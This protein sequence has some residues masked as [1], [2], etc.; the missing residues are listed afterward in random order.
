MRSSRARGIVLVL[1]VVALTMGVVTSALA[2]AETYTTR[3]KTAADSSLTI[4]FVS[5][6]NAGAIH[7]NLNYWTSPVDPSGDFEWFN[8]DVQITDFALLDSGSGEPTLTY[9]AVRLNTGAGYDAWETVLEPFTATQDGVYSVAATGTDFLLG[10]VAGEITP[11]FGIDTVDP[12]I[13]TDRVPYYSSTA[14]VTVTATDTMS[15]MESVLFSVDGDRNDSWEPDF[16]DPSTF[17]A[18]FPFSGEGMHSISW[19]G[20]DNA[21]NALHGSVTFGIGH[22]TI[23]PSRSNTH[24]TISPN[25]TQTV[26]YGASKTFT[27]KAKHGYRISKVLVDGHSVGARSSYRFSNVKSNH[28]IKAYF[29]HR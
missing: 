10:E 13:T 21:G 27:M 19:T 4:A 29:V 20:F 5:R 1:A 12:I 24:G 16:G 2:A 22:H 18:T 28:T 15:G 26:L 3:S 14:N 8:Q 7:G 6:G 17:S 11:A 9:A 23:K 25:T